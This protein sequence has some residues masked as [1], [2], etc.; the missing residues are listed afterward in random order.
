M[1]KRSRKS[2]KLTNK[3]KRFCEEYLVDLNATQAA[4][5]AGYSKHTAGSIGEEN[6]RKPEIKKYVAKLQEKLSKETGITA[7]MVIDELAKIGFSNIQDFIDS[8]NSVKDI[9]DIDRSQAAAVEGVKKIVTEWGEG[10]KAG[11]RTAITFKLYDKGAA[12]ERLGKHLGVFE[13]DNK[14]RNNNEPVKLTLNIAPPPK[15]ED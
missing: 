8:D 1:P 13:K 15:D 7:K 9:S 10:K 2:G 4:I 11:K 14:Q 12:L 3:Q 6:L 5:R